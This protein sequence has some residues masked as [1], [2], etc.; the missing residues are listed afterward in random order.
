MVRYTRNL[1]F[2]SEISILSKRL[3]NI[4]FEQQISLCTEI[5]AMLAPGFEP[6]HSLESASS[7]DALDHSAINC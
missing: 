1:V 2:L 4:L 5:R 7:T 3:T 6:M